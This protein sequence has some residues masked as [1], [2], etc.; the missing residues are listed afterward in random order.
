MKCL[1]ALEQKNLLRV[2]KMDNVYGENQN[3]E[4]DSPVRS[5]D[6]F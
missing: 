2:F 3:S 4:G 5:F 1:Y 6:Q